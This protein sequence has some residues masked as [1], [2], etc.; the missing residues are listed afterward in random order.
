MNKEVSR[1]VVTEKGPF[2]LQ[3]NQSAAKGLAPAAC[4]QSAGN[5]KGTGNR[6][7]GGYLEQR[8]GHGAPH[9]RDEGG[10]HNLGV[11]VP[12]VHQCMGGAY[13]LLHDPW[14][15]SKLKFARKTRNVCRLGLPL[16]WTV[17]MVTL[18][19]FTSACL[20]DDSPDSEGCLLGG[21]WGADCRRGRACSG[22]GAMELGARACAAHSPSVT[23]S[24]LRNRHPLPGHP[25]V[26]LLMCL[27]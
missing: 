24:H 12:E 13:A 25:T 1:Q 10:R 16:L 17:L 6:C 26:G 15:E 11:S 9:R 7:W 18:C 4:P 3:P 20:F 21:A 19:L 23:S 8:A 22:L 27:C 14:K 5:V 2:L